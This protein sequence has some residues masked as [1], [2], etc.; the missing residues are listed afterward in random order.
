MTDA[1]EPWRKGAEQKAVDELVG[2]KSHSA[3]F[4]SVGGAVL[5][6]IR[7]LSMAKAVR[8]AAEVFQYLVRTSEGRFGETT[9][10]IRLRAAVSLKKAACS[11]SGV[12]VPGKHRNVPK[13]RFQALRGRACGRGAITYEPAG[14]SRAARISAGLR[15]GCAIRKRNRCARTDGGDRRQCLK[16]G[17][18]G[19]KQVLYICGLLRR[20]RLLSCPGM[21]KTT[22]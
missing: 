18:A 15:R 1:R 4:V 8:V 5:F 9:H 11:R 17:D 14:R 16:R 10:S 20:T 12:S 3:G 22:W 13:K 6:S 21:V 2:G 7:R 19:G